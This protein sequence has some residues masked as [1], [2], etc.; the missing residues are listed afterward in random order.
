MQNKINLISGQEEEIEIA[1]K[2]NFFLPNSEAAGG[3][4][5]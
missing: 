4:H 1:Q 3:K 5:S 2:R